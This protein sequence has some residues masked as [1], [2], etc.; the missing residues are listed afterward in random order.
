MP[1]MPQP[2]YEFRAMDRTGDGLKL[3]WRPGNTA[4]VDA[5]RETFQS[6]RDR[7]YNIFR[8]NENDERGGALTSFDPN[9]GSLLAVPRMVGG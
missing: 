3:T 9:A 1:K 4:E 7:G 5:A 6:Y 2:P 8:L